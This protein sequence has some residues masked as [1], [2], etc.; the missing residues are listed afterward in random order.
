MTLHTIWSVVWQKRNSIWC[1]RSWNNR[2]HCLPYGRRDSIIYKHWKSLI[3]NQ[4]SHQCHFGDC[5]RKA[6]L[7]SALLGKCVGMR[8]LLKGIWNIS[9]ELDCATP[10][11]L[12]LKVSIALLYREKDIL[13]TFLANLTLRSLKDIRCAVNKV[14]ERHMHLQWLCA[15]KCSVTVFVNYINFNRRTV[16]AGSSSVSRVH[17][18]VVRRIVFSAHINFDLY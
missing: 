2:N 17:T 13:E 7:F 8:L 6:R 18:S 10:H 3:H 4:V 15:Q 9:L 1:G 12:N 14:V 16:S 11:I 5:F